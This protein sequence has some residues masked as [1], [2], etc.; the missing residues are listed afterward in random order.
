[1]GGGGEKE[2]KIRWFWAGEASGWREQ[3]EQMRTKQ[4]GS[5]EPPNLKPETLDI[6]IQRKGGREGGREEG[7]GGWRERGYHVS[8]IQGS[9]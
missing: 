5:N 6:L 3:A 8:C 7:M 1:V 2:R 9:L 4:Q